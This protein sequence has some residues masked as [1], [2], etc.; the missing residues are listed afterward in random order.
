MAYLVTLANERMRERAV[1]I[2]TAKDSAGNYKLKPGSR[3]EIKGP[4]RSGAQNRA[5][6]PLLADM[7]EQLVWYGRKLSPDAW[8]LV[9]LDALR[10]YRGDEMDI[11]QNSDLTGFVLLSGQ[12]SSELDHEEMSDLLTIIN[13]F[14]DQNGVVWTEPKP[15]DKRPTPPVEAYL[16]D[17][18][19]G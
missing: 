4:K 10:R 2:I 5:M 1:E 19:N 8:K 13:A 11:V 9:M 15:K 17:N 16:G 12:S 7:S 3:V 6:W 14:G 18:H